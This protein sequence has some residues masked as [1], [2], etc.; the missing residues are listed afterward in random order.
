NLFLDPQLIQTII[1][2]HLLGNYNFSSNVRGRTFPKGMSV[3][4][5]NVDYYLEKFPNFN[6]EDFEH[7]MTYFY[8]TDN[9]SH[10][11]HYSNFDF[12]ET[13][14]F[15]IDTREDFEKATMIIGRMHGN[16]LLFDMNG[17]IK[18]YKNI[19]EEK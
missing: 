18:L 1:E 15:A 9:R 2:K 19:D 5:V 17:I 4:V 11:H 13:L 3:E 10:E 12:G 6:M 8:R 7:V 16:H 14:N